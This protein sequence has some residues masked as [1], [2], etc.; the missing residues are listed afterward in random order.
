MPL[1][2]C[3]EKTLLSGFGPFPARVS[4]HDAAAAGL[5]SP[6]CACVTRPGPRRSPCADATRYL[7]FWGPLSVPR[8]WPLLEEDTG[9][10]EVDRTPTT[11]TIM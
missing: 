6:R 9:V 5:L 1:L 8:V 10:T 2:S 3:D 4:C 11:T 7:L